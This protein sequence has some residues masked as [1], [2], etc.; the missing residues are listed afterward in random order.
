VRGAD[1]GAPAVL[2]LLLALGEEDLLAQTARVLGF[3]G[4]G[5]LIRQPLAENLEALRRQGRCLKR[6]ESVTLVPVPG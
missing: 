1:C 2:Q 5:D 4:L 3:G 6:G